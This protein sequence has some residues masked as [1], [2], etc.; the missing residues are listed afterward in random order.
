M[1]VKRRASATIIRAANIINRRSTPFFTAAEASPS[2]SIIGG[3]VLSTSCLSEAISCAPKRRTTTIGMVLYSWIR[4]Q[5]EKNRGYR[6][7][8]DETI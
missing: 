3:A 7:L 1:A 6:A 8:L 4:T 5:F 2:T